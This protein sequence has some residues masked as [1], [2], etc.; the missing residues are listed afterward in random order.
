MMFTHVQKLRTTIRSSHYCR[1]YGATAVSLVLVRRKNTIVSQ[2]IFVIVDKSNRW[3]G[4]MVFAQLS[5]PF[6]CYSCSWLMN[7][8]LLLMATFLWAEPTSTA[9]VDV[10]SCIRG[11]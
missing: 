1:S 4:L 2:K 6:R 10:F 5:G 8:S 3:G 11:G 7:E 9:E